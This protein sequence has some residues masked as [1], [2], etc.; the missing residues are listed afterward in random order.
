MSD[1]PTPALETNAKRALREQSDQSLLDYLQGMHSET[2]I[3]VT[4]VRETP[5]M[6]KGRN[7]E[8]TLETFDEPISE[9]E[10]RELYGGGKYKLR[11]QTPNAKGSYVYA[12]HRTLKIAGDPKLDHMAVEEPSAEDQPNVVRETLRLSERLVDRA[13]KRADQVE[14]RAGQRTA[15][16]PSVEL[17]VRSMQEQLGQVSR[18]SAA[19]DT[20]IHELLTRQNQRGPTDMLL[21]KMLDGDS[22]RI[23]AI[24]TQH[25][26]ELRSVRERHLAEMDR[27]AARFD[28]QSRRFDDQARQ[29]GNVHGREI[30]TIKLAH[31]SLSEGLKSQIGHL[32]RELASAKSEL[33]ALRTKKDKSVLDSVSELAA[34]REA[35]GVF[36][37]GDDG[38][39]LDRVLSALMSS[40][41]VSRIGER[42]AAPAVPP[43]LAA[44]I[45]VPRIALPRPPSPPSAEF[46]AESRQPPKPAPA[47]ETAPLTNGLEL[48]ESAFASGTDPQAFAQTA[49][50]LIG[51]D[52]ATEL[53]AAGPDALVQQISAA[54][55]SSPLVSSQRG[56]NWIRA[57]TQLLA[58][59]LP[60]REAES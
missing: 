35:L 7:I 26:A 49:R 20:R 34:V 60:D 11:I 36:G 48:M 27:L 4:V 14:E 10:I 39:T 12:A 3:R 25:E 55:P 45:P 1:K 47:P 42:L 56:K 53:S 19:K 37:G 51:P 46:A 24:R 33:T 21:E 43:V 58:K 59:D 30:D 31:Q 9:D 57:V 40:P 52:I 2:S 15:M 16:D 5:K 22:A 23:A 38:S 41:I 54:S 50:S 8:G 44:P 18:D 32:E 6:W 17:L 13:H 29:L 28:D